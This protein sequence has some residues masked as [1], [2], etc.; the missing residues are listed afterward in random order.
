[1]SDTDLRQTGSANPIDNDATEPGFLHIEEAPEDT[2]PET[3]TTTPATEVK[4]VVTSSSQAMERAG[5]VEHLAARRPT[6]ELDT[7]SPQVKQ[8]LS[9]LRTEVTRLLTA[10]RWEG[11]SVEETT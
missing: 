10:L 6:P 8:Q 3:S 5:T 1:M 4:Q 9:E 7:N 2:P 11:L